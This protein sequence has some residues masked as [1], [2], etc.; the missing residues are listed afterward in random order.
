MEGSPRPGQDHDHDGASDANPRR[1]RP[2]SGSN[3]SQ[4]GKKLKG[5]K[6]LLENLFIHPYKYFIY[7]SNE[8]VL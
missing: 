2:N 3:S 7:M 6:I 8:L 4:M 5:E 1:R